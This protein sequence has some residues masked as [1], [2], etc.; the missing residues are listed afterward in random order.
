MKIRNIL[1]GFVAVSAALGFSACQDDIDAPRSAY[2]VPQATIKAN[3]TIMEVKEAFWKDETPYCVEIPARSDGE[4]YIIA[5][6]VISSDYDGNVFKCIYLRDETG[7][8][9]ISINAYNLW[10]TCRIG[11]EVVV[12][13]TGMYIGRYAGLM[14]LGYPK[15]KASANTYEPTF[16]AQSFFENHIQ[17]NGLPEPSKV[18]PVLI[19]SLGDLNANSGLNNGEF[20]RKW[21]GQL[22]RLNNVHFKNADGKTT[23]CAEY[24]S[25][26]ESQPLVDAEGNEIN[27]R[28]SGY[29][30]FYN[31]VLPQGSGDVVALLG[32]YYSSSKTS[33]W[34]LVLISE[35]GLMNFGSPTLPSGT[36]EKPWTVDEA[37]EKQRNGETP[38]GWVE[39]FIVGTVAPEVETI[40]S[41]D[42]I[43]WGANAT[44]QNTVVIGATPETKDLNACLVM[45]LPQSSK[46]RQ[47]VALATHPENLGK[48]LAVLGTLDKYMGAY[49]L[50][51]VS[52]EPADFRLEGVTVPD[53]PEQ[54]DE[55]TGIPDGNGTQA[56]PYSPAQML[57]MGAPASAQANVYVKGYIVGFIP[58]KSISE[59]K[60]ELP[61]TSKTNIVISSTPDGNSSTTVVP[62]QLPNGAI[63]TALNLQDNPGNFGKIVTLC[64]SYEKY[65]GVA[66]LKSVTSYKFE[67]GMGPDVPDTPDTPAGATLFSETFASGQGAFTIDNITLGTGMSYVWNFDDRYSCMKASAFVGGSNHAAEARLISPE[68]NLSGVSGAV[69]TFDQA[70]KF[71]GSLDN[72]VKSAACE[73]STDGGSTWTAL[74]VPGQTQYDSWTFVPSG[75]VDLSA[76]VGKTVKIAFHYQ[77]TSSTAGTWEVKNVLVTSK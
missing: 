24:H 62:V 9:P 55:P 6:R 29:S 72:C 38:S 76:Y 20:L 25:S 46:M 35:D 58:D 59:A 63:R 13:L 67:D 71:F 40:T 48:K 18:E 2:E 66:G 33:P 4:H 52:G 57:S 49:G 64:G 56:S 15:W 53:T 30:S 41:A 65:F 21:Q 77:S 47:Y 75:N 60:F 28:T 37:N 68:I 73:I 36:S 74:T 14:Q 45:S 32:Y 1:Y 10:L 44:L 27:V 61:A 8:M 7:V 22:V 39:G 16:M 42:Q 11:Q 34:Q 54:P 69:L 51:G 70:C 43:Q 31:T 3:A 23:L 5:G 12:D 50:T 19:E 17:L 26:G